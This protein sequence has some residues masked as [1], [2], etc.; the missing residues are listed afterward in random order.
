MTTSGTTVWSMTA[1]ELIRTALT[2][3]AIIALGEV[4]TAD[5]ETECLTRLNG[6]LK[7]WQLKGV[8]WKQETET[9][10]LTAATASV[11]L[12]AYV[13]GLNSARF[14]ESADFER[15]LQRFERD[16]YYRLPNKT[17]AGRPTCYYVE[18]STSGLTLFVWPVQ[19]VDSNLKIDIDRAMDTVTEGSETVDIPEELQETVYSCL[20]VRCAGIFGVTPTQILYERAMMLEREMLDSYRPASYY[21]EAY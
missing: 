3:N 16:E 17:S 6:M 13:R 1:A 5:E 18:R 20:A 7:S 2:E 21:F 4:P 8:S 11:A 9:L 19:T 15:M 10:A 14:V 12:P